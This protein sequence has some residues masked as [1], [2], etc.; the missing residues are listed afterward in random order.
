MADDQTEGM[1]RK[2][3]WASLYG[4]NPPEIGGGANK[5]T[6]DFIVNDKVQGLIDAATKFLHGRKVVP[7]EKLRKEAVMDGIAREVMKARGLSSP[8]GFAKEQPNSAYK[9]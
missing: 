2:T 4:T 9:E 5:V 1:S 8:I 6:F 3:L 7:N